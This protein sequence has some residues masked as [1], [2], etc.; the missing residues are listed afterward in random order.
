MNLIREI[1]DWVKTRPL[2]FQDAVRRLYENPLGLTAED[3][4]DI[5]SLFKH[6]NGLSSECIHCNFAN[7]GSPLQ[8]WAL[9]RTIER[10]GYKPVLMD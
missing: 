5:Y 10:L 1:F 3:Y 2:W 7:Y 8:S 6:E 4:G 9:G